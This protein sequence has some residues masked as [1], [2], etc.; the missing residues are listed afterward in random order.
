MNPSKNLSPHI[1]AM[2]PT[3]TT[4]MTPNISG[5]P[6][7]NTSPPA[8]R[9]PNMNLRSRVTASTIFF[10]RQL[11]DSVPKNVSLKENATAA[12]E[13]E[14]RLQLRQRPARLRAGRAPQQIKNIYWGPRTPAVPA[15]HLTSPSKSLELAGLSFGGCFAFGFNCLRWRRPL[16]QHHSNLVSLS[17]IG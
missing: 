5:I 16:S 2:I 4:N 12:T 10:S 3:A 6:P 17:I 8:R 13:R 7:H 11:T 1:A 9:A 14:N 15:N